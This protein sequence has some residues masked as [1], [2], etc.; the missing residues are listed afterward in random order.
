M[1]T[2]K[3][4]IRCVVM[5]SSWRI[6]GD[7]HILTGSRLTDTLNSRAKDFFVVTDAVISDVQTG[8]ELHRASYVAVNRGE[9]SLIFP[10]E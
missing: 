5:V 9:A 8:A 4:R 3:D 6:E 1:Q 7:V 10:A 2:N